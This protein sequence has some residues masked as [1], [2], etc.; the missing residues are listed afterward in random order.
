HSI[1][2]SNVTLKVLTPKV[3]GILNVTPDSFSDGGNWMDVDRAQEQA[4]ELVRQG[5][6]AIDIGG[7]STRPGSV[8]VSLQEELARVIPVLEAI[9]GKINVPISIDTRRAKVAQ[10]AVDLGASMINDTS[11]LQ[12]DP[13]LVHVIADAQVKVVLM[14]RQGIPSTMQSSPGY[15]DVIG[16]IRDYL[17]DRIK[18]CENAGILRESIIVDPGL[19][20]G[21]RLVD[22]Y[23]IGRGLEEFRAL[24]V[25]LLIGASRKSFTG[26]FDDSPPENRLPA[27]LAFV[28]RA[29]DAGVEWVRVHDVRETVTFLSALAAIENPVLV[30]GGLS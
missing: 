28:S 1:R 21:K 29:R 27:S 9:S 13:E 8:E 20:F 16:E 18:F 5:A 4:L 22:N 23:E 17:I 30:E 3:L 6:D 11:A 25:P 10:A 12:D 19:G 24:G 15:G 14:H 7:E 2:K 26:T